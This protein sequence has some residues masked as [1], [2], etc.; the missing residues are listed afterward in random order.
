MAAAMVEALV[1]PLTGTGASRWVV[2]PSPNC[3]LG[4]FPHA[5]GPPLTVMA[6]G[7]GTGVKVGTT[8]S[9]VAR[10]ARLWLAP[11]AM[12]VMPESPP[13][14]T[15]KLRLFSRVPVPSWPVLLKPQ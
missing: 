11:A 15:G 1:S 5:Q 3:P 6:V 9:G 4:L 12:V 14:G 7:V 8:V 13:A 2:V 10:S